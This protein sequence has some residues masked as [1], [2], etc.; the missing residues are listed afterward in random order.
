M[1]TPSIATEDRQRWIAAKLCGSLAAGILL[2]SSM[3]ATQGADADEQAE[4]EFF[5]TKIRPL[6]VSRCYACHSA[7]TKPAGDLRVDDYNGLLRG[8]KSGPGVVP[9][10]DKASLLLVRILETDESKR[11]PQDAEPLS[12]AE[13]ADL[14]RWVQAGA[15]WP[16]A[17]EPEYETEDLSDLYNDLR[18]DHW[19][20]QPLQA[21]P[22]PPVEQADWPRDDIDRFVL[23]RLEAAGLAPVADADR[24]TLLRRVTFDLTGLPPTEAELE[25]FLADSSENA[26]ETVVDRLLASEGFGQHWGRHW[27]D[28]ARYGESTG[29][30]RNIPYPHAW[31]YRN[32]VIDSVNRDVPINRFIQEQIA[33]DLI[34]EQAE[35][36]ANE[37]RDRLLTATGFLALGVKD[38]N[39]RFK[40]RF[41]MDNI[42]E[43]IDAVTRGV[44]G[45]TVSC[46]R[47]HDHKFDPIP[48]ADY[49]ALAGIFAS[50]ENAASVRNKMGGSG[51]DYYNPQSL[52]RLSIELPPP[53]ED[54][55]RRLEEKVGETKA[56]WDAIRG[57][58]EGLAKRPNGQLV[59]R[60]FRLA[61][62]Q[63]Q[64]D[65]LMLTDPAA[66]GAVVHGV[67]EAAEIADTAIRYR[68]EAEQLGEVV[69]RGFLTAFAVPDAAPINRQ[70]SGRLE[71]AQWLTSDLNPLSPRVAANLIWQNLFGTGLVSTADNFGNSGAS[72]SHPELLD[73]VAQRLI[74]DGWSR[75][76]LIRQLVL[77]RTYR[78]SAVATEE[79]LQIDPANRLLGRHT[80][81]RLTSD[82]L[83]DAALAVS[84]ALDRTPAEGTASSELRMVEM[85]DNG[86]EA[87]AVHAQSD[88]S[89]RRSIYLP[90]VRGVTP[91][92]LEC[93]DPAEQSLVTVKRDATTVPS[94]A[95][96]LLNSDFVKQQAQQLTQSIFE[97]PTADDVERVQ[98]T[99]RRAF[100]RAASE[101]EVQQA[102]SFIANF[103]SLYAQQAAA[104]VNETAALSDGA[105]EAPEYQLVASRATADNYQLIAWETWHQSLLAAA[106]FR[107]IR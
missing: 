3:A 79:H 62:E 9:G 72:P 8:G 83:R 52:I 60:R 103:Q 106:E 38:V 69:P 92:S 82:E 100:G 35:T 13:I 102:L 49:Y 32:Y 54:E 88:A 93:F 7:E 101:Q 70:Q 29:P 95:L 107:F 59:Q 6:L 85:R 10:D 91:R 77:S 31:R 99:Y 48:T 18:A 12:E 34:A 57:T 17:P 55:V 66:R 104:T 86:A 94:Q 105:A 64:A 19:A 81:R 53:L 20:F 28:V 98:T 1:M 97:L 24:E 33:G 76:A 44:L 84:G 96:F 75:K 56:A 21:A 68:G 45:L 23:A 5:E 89:T 63:A 50:T 74:D 51:L 11:M 58:P 27:L 41:E 30:S 37:E 40:I 67:R 78:L 2:L 39:Q 42:D 14:V 43:Q 87:K 15:K 22:I 26:F 4:H 47:C 65:L 25:A 90:L 36:I 73:Y 80:P 71:L 46:A 61:W 16:A